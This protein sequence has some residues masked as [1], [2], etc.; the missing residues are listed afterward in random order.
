MAD[1]RIGESGFV[2][3]FDDDGG[4]VEFAA[5]LTRAA[6][7]AQF[8]MGLPEAQTKLLSALAVT[9]PTLGAP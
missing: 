3:K 5:D 8:N 6:A 2:V 1:Y 4:M 9:Y 7:G